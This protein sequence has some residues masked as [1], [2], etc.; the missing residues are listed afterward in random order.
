MIQ[1][2]PFIQ[3]FEHLKKTK[4]IFQHN[5]VSANMLLREINFITKFK[6]EA[7]FNIQYLFEN[8]SI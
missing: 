6:S 2:K 3:T 4:Y 8:K 1:K 7:L 5:F